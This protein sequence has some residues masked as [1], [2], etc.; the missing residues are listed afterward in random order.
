MLIVISLIALLGII[1]FCVLAK[2]NPYDMWEVGTFLSGVVFI[3]SV[4]AMF[5]NGYHIH[6]CTYV[7]PAQ[8]TMYEEENAK[9]EEKVSSTVAKYM[10]YEGN[11]IMEIAPG[12]DAMSLISLYPDLKS[13]QLIMSEIN[14]Y[15][16]NNDKIKELKEQQLNL[17]TYKWWLYFGH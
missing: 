12:D 17:R 6:K 4:L 1:V 9:I 14:I 11:V 10:E 7:I 13:D 2:D 3:V 16:E 8:I 15:I 5:W